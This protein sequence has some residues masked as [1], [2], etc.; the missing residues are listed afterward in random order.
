MITKPLHV[1]KFSFSASNIFLFFFLLQF[2]MFLSDFLSLFQMLMSFFLSQLHM[3]LF[4]LFF[5]GSCFSL[6]LPNWS[7]CPFLFVRLVPGRFLGLA[8]PVFFPF[9]LCIVFL[10]DQGPFFLYFLC[11]NKKQQQQ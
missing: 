5:S 3:F 7:L 2:Q 8:H 9:C 4:F 1:L 6:R 11:N 10:L